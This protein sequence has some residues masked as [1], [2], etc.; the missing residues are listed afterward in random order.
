[1]PELSEPIDPIHAMSIQ[2]TAAIRAKVLDMKMRVAVWEPRPV[3][4]FR[5]PVRR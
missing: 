5:M 2:A 3:P 4:P 1:M